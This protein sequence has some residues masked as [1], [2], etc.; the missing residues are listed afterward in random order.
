M[1]PHT[2]GGNTTGDVEMAAREQATSH[3]E[4]SLSTTTVPTL[5]PS[6]T[7][8]V[9]IAAES[10]ASHVSSEIAWRLYLSHFLSTW[11]SRCFE[12]GSVL[13]F[14]AIY[15][16]TLLYLSIY[17]IC[18]SAAG[19]ILATA[20]GKAIDS[21][22]RLRIV[23]IS[24]VGGRMAVI[25]SSL[26]IWSLWMYKSIP[27]NANMALFSG[28]ILL[29]CVEK[30][31]SM[32]N[33]VAVERD[34]DAPNRSRLQACGPTIHSPGRWRIDDGGY[35]ASPRTERP[36]LA[37]RIPGYCA[38]KSSD[39]KQPELMKTQK[40]TPRTD[41]DDPIRKVYSR[42]PDLRLPKPSREHAPVSHN[43]SQARQIQQRL[44]SPFTDARRALTHYSHH[45]AFTP[46]LTL[47]LLYLTVLSFSG[48]MTTYLLSAGLN[49]FYIGLIRSL[50]VLIELSATWLAPRLMFR[51]SPARSAMWFLNWQILWLAGT[52][53]FF[54]SWEGRRGGMVAAWGLAV[55]T[56][57]SRV[58][59]WGYDLSAQ[60][61]IQT[62]VEVVHRGS[63]STTEAALQNLFELLAYA[64]TIAL[65]QPRQFK[66]PV[67][68]SG[69]VVLAAGFLYAYYLRSR[70]GHLVHI[71]C[72]TK[73]SDASAEA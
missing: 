14:A 60:V 3:N 29:S 10:T 38:S 16:Q 66:F 20:I 22:P 31:A 63:F 30:A 55:G 52:V 70:R 11:N 5:Q 36:L 59:L 68:V 9:H 46:S 4:P 25:L 32:M 67:L 7:V 26:G 44:I 35:M 8:P 12:F 37:D 43:T 65:P 64:L 24:I 19:M 33:L 21:Q 2:N 72:T 49:T 57:M 1:R 42:V 45:R 34:W 23:R 53:T 56:I 28:L 47:A 61:I 18:R 13:F 51:I 71:P 15:S 50:S 39:P 73:S 48:Q 40:K 69:V 54:W 62:E 27:W 17:A 41:R 58:G 6:E